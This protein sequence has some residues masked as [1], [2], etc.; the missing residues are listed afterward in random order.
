MLL[1]AMSKLLTTKESAEKL[2][3]SV[4]RVQALITKNQLKAEK[5]GRDYMIREKDLQNIKP[6]INGRPLGSSNKPKNK[7]QE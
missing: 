6:G 4:R 3:V 1:I 7:E 2:G 5:I